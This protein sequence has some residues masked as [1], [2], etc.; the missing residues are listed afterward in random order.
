MQKEKRKFEGVWIPKNLWLNKELT[1]QEKVFFVEINSLDNE[2]GCFASNAYFADFFRL[3]KGRVSQIIKSLIDKKLL[4]VKYI[5]KGKMVEKRVL[6][7]LNTP[8]NK[9]N[10]KGIKKTK[11]GSKFPKGGYLE[12]DKDNSTERNNTTNKDNC[13]VETP[14]V[15]KDLALLNK[16]LTKKNKKHKDSII[17]IVNYFKQITGRDRISY[18]TKGA[19]TLMLYWLNEGKTIEDFKK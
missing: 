13:G 5:K 9:T 11:G 14:R 19:L 3:T 6:R 17:T 8:P 16:R 1:L 10:K 4:S 12:N 7:I 2:D 15:K 18:S